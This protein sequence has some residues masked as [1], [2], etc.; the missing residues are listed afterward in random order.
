MIAYLRSIGVKIPINGTNHSWY[1]NF[2]RWEHPEGTDIR[3]MVGEIENTFIR[4]STMRSLE[5]PFFVSEWDHA[6]PA[7]Y[8][9]ES[10]L[11]YAAVGALQGWSGFTIHTYRYGT[12]NPVD[13]MGATTINGVTYRMHFDAF[14]DPAKFGDAANG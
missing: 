2:P 3:P 6:W 4:L 11:I 1:W 8:R 10:P 7:P 5:A 12:H 13:C 14:N 9:A